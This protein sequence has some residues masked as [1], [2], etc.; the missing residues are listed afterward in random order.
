MEVHILHDPRRPEKLKQVMDEVTRQ[1]IT[2]YEVWFGT[3]ESGSA[4]VEVTINRMHKR[5][6]EYAKNNSLAC[7]CILEDDVLFPAP[8]GWQY[9]L[10]HI[11]QVDYNLYL[12]GHYGKIDRIKQKGF[13]H[14]VTCDRPSGFHC[15][16]I[17]QC[18]YDTFLRTPDDVHIDDYQTE[19]PL[20]VCFPFAAVQ[21][22]G[23]SSVLKK[24][25]VDYNAEIR[26]KKWVY[27][28]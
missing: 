16:T 10:R 22:P 1:G 28:W 4:P 20:Y 3:P 21:S 5:I 6:V 9:F 24:N 19:Q 17:H 18:Y 13:D 11:P 14:L 2:E 15:Y 26:K 12:G 7:V 27:G 23:W 25:G 8:D